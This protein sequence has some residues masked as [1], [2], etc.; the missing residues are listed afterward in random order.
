MISKVSGSLTFLLESIRSQK[1]ETLAIHAHNFGSKFSQFQNP[2]N[3]RL[4]RAVLASVKAHSGTLTNLFIDDKFRRVDDNIPLSPED[5]VT[6]LCLKCFQYTSLRLNQEDYGL[7]L[8]KD[9][10]SLEQLTLTLS[11]SQIFSYLGLA[12]TAPTP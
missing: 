12:K 11:M 1:L 2:Q 9:F 10:R 8:L 6:Q 3:I 5:K 4:L 7:Q